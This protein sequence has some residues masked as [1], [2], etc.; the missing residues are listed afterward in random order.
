MS[1]SQLEDVHTDRDLQ[2]YHCIIW[3]HQMIAGLI[4]NTEE[5][6][7]WINLSSR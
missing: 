1:C 3:W 6:T 5:S 4:G 7:L 2:W